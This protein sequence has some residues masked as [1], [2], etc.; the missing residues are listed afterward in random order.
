MGFM[1]SIKGSY[2]NAVRRSLEMRVS[3]PVTSGVEFIGLIF[4]RSV[5]MRQNDKGEIYFEGVEGTFTIINYEWTGPIYKEVITQRSVTERKGK[6][7][8][9][10]SLG[11]AVIGG[12][13][14]GP[15]G[16]A[17]G[18]V[19]AGKTKRGGKDITT[20]TISS[21]NV[22]M[23]A[24]G[25]IT[26][27]NNKTGETHTIGFSILSSTNAKIL[28]F[29]M[30]CSQI[31]AESEVVEIEEKSSLDLLKEYKELLDLGILTQEEFDQ[32]KKEL[33]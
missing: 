3:L 19:G 30:E 8:R 17:A 9:K 31:V 28:N 33:L 18:Y 23:P 26:L 11:G 12:A 7:K 14:L 4:S 1:D 13:L 2:D 21:R 29:N 5:V 27:K 24:P 10:G 15:V 22:E 20:A 16:A 6:D 25:T 32:K